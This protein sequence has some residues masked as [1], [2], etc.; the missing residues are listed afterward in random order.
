[1]RCNNCGSN[2]SEADAASGTVYCVDC[3]TVL[4]ENTIVAEVTFGETAG[5]KA[6]LQGSFAGDSGRQKIASLAHGL[7]LP[8]R[9]REAGQRYY[10][11]A[12]VNRFTR[13]RKS[14]HVAAVN[15][16]TLGAT[17]L[18]LCRVLNLILPHVDPSFYISRFAVALD[19]GDYTQRV[20]QDAVRIAQ[21]MDRDWIVTGRR[22][23]GICGACLLIAA[24]M[25][26][27][28]R[29]LREMI[30]VVKVAE[31]TIQKRLN[32]FNQTESAQLSAQDFRTI[33]LE[34]RADPP[35]FQKN[36]KKDANN[37]NAESEEEKDEA[38]NILNEEPSEKENENNNEI[39]DSLKNL[40]KVDLDESQTQIA[41]QISVLDEEAHI[42]T[43]VEE[44]GDE[45][46]ADYAH[47]TKN[48][49][50]NDL[51]EEE[52]LKLVTTAKTRVAR[53]M[54][55]LLNPNLAEDVKQIKKANNAPREVDEEE[56]EEEENLSD[57]DC[58]EIEAMILTEE[59]VALKTKLWYNANK[60]YLEE[61]AVRR[62]VE[63]DKGTGKDKRT[64]GS[65]K[66]K[67]Q[68]PASTPAEAAKQLLATKK[69]SKK[70]NQA[71]FDDM[72]ESPESIEKIKQG[73]K[74][75]IDETGSEGY[76]VVEEP[77]EL[78]QAKAQKTGKEE[79]ED[80]DDDDDEEE[81][82]EDENT[83]YPTLNYQQDYVDYDD[84]GDDGD[85][86]FY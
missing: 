70:I 20:A 10:N 74:R 31:V 78:P 16:F 33:W 28:R 22:P 7:R 60:E 72:F 1:M 80:V 55:V 26:G 86:D 9:Y 13:G 75:N 47:I 76:E 19:F 71:V 21:R 17:F 38:V 30:Y 73:T 82:E 41:S 15:V 48:K 43:L 83:E 52:K 24:R 81:E 77:G 14:E 5:G 61:M 40:Q 68:V 50:F 6:I 54:E 51:S 67:Q 57:V 63:K 39:G 25:N 27:F 84:Y 66:K 18:K 29:T 12:V 64:K 85:D 46:A 69:L 11:L 32:E 8:E 37:T 65:R 34:K 58:D 56:D 4:E 53:E 23:A 35:S 36:R 2:K 59:E 45:G 49:E 42:S 3:G 79:E 44:L 62:L